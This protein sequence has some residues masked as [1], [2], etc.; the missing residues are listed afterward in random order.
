MEREAWPHF[1][2]QEE[3]DIVNFIEALTNDST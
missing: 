1:R 3:E 2:K